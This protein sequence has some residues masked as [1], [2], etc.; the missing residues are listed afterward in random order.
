MS[1]TEPNRFFET[2]PLKQDAY[3]IGTRMPKRDMQWSLTEAFSI[4][5]GFLTSHWKSGSIFLQVKSLSKHA[6]REMLTLYNFMFQYD[7]WCKSHWKME[8][9]CMEHLQSAKNDAPTTEYC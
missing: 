8:A 3:L 2:E 9:V 6:S 7:A 1:H 4:S 5:H